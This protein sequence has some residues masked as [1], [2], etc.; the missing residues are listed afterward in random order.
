MLQSLSTSHDKFN[1]HKIMGVS[2]LIL[3]AYR[4]WNL[5]DGA[6]CFGASDVVAAGTMAWHLLLPASSFMFKVPDK[7]ILPLMIWTEMRWHTLLFTTRCTL[8]FYHEMVFPQSYQFFVRFL[9]VISVHI[10][11][12]CVTLM[13]GQKN[14]TTIRVDGKSEHTW[15]LTFYS[16]SQFVGTAGMLGSFNGPQTLTMAYLP[17]IPIFMASFGMTLARKQF[18]SKH[19]YTV[20]YG[21][22][23]LGIWYGVLRHKHGSLMCAVGIVVSQL[24]IHSHIN[25]YALWA[26]ASLFMS[27]CVQGVRSIQ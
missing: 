7:R 1:M 20:M 25:K 11:V 18:I 19:G 17:L 22:P 26:G 23:L 21:I 9:M 4:L 3:F 10:L 24:R 6:E 12:D 8:V 2:T 16:I 15:I 13:Y 27:S 5:W 14:N